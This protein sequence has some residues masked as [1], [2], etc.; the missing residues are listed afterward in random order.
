MTLL[1][2]YQRFKLDICLN[3]KLICAPGIPDRRCNAAFACP[4]FTSTSAVPVDKRP[5]DGVTGNLLNFRSDLLV[6]LHDCATTIV[7]EFP[8]VRAICSVVV[9]LPAGR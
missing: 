3:Q 6:G 4:I 9:R 7:H 5:Q 2:N 1:S 8:A